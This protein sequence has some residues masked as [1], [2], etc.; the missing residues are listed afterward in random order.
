MKKH[1]AV[2]ALASLV[3]LAAFAQASNPQ[4]APAQGGAATPT[5]MAQTPAPMSQ[6]ADKAAPAKHKHHHHHHHHHKA[7]ATAASNA[8]AG[9]Q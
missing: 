8:S 2:A 9:S 6:P 3:S 7:A 1:F 4:V 5:P